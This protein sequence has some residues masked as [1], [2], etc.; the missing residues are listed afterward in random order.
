MCCDGRKWKRKCKMKNM[1]TIENDNKICE[2][3]AGERN[4]F[5]SINNSF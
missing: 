3:C 4:A 1:G 2:C 5:Y